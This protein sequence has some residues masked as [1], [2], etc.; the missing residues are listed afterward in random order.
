[1]SIIVYWGLEYICVCLCSLWYACM[2][3][4]LR[5]RVNTSVE[6]NLKKTS[7]LVSEQRHTTWNF[8]KRFHSATTEIHFLKWCI[9]NGSL[10][11]NGQIIKTW[12]RESLRFYTRRGPS[13]SSLS[14]QYVIQFP[15][16]CFIKISKAPN[17][18]FFGV[19]DLS[20]PVTEAPPDKVI[21]EKLQCYKHDKSQCL[22][23]LSMSIP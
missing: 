14:V 15:R 6:R 22:T 8:K 10:R 23:F 3:Q 21:A 2:K 9:G 19:M 4:S 11:T 1:M 16:D 7:F 5:T 17:A 18:I 20:S 12:F 13:L